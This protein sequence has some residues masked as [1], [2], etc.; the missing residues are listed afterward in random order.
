M[1]FL[2]HH[3]GFP[4]VSA[5]VYMVTHRISLR[6]NHVNNYQVSWFIKLLCCKG[7][8]LWENIEL[9][10]KSLVAL[11]YEWDPKVVIYS[12]WIRSLLIKTGGNRY[13]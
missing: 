11:T 7:C 8:Q 4:I 10:M 12:L 5:L 6:I 9:G 3:S 13:V 1:T 2:G